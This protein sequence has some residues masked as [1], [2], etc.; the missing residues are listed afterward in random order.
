MIKMMVD[1][2]SGESMNSDRAAEKLAREKLRICGPVNKLAF[3]GESLYDEAMKRTVRVYDEN[4]KG[5]NDA[6]SEYL[7]RICGAPRESEKTTA[8][9]EK[10][11]VD[12]TG[13]HAPTMGSWF[14]EW[15][16]HYKQECRH[17]DGDKLFLP[18]RKGDADIAKA[19]NDILD[20]TAFGNLDM[21]VLAASEADIQNLCAKLSAA[22]GRGNVAYEFSPEESSEEVLDAIEAAREYLEDSGDDRAELPEHILA[23]AGYVSQD[24]YEQTANENDGGGYPSL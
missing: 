4:E 3:S 1:K 18:V 8:E 21:V 20:P 7:A 11:F 5:L 24:E 10:T 16:S 15:I 23:K 13:M 9:L 19:L 17:G 2:N 14:P 6:V 12:A 22:M